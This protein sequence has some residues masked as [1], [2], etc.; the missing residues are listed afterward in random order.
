[1]SIIIRGNPVKYVW[2]AA[3]IIPVV[4]AIAAVGCD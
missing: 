1:M 2:Y 3:M 4:I